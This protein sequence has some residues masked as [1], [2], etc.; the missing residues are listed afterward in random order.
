MIK[1]TVT[2][3]LMLDFVDD[4]FQIPV[5]INP[6]RV[7]KLNDK[8]IKDG[9]IV[10][11]MSREL[12]LEDN[13]GLLF[14]FN[15]AK[16]KHLPFKVVISLEKNFY[17]ERQLKFMK[18]GLDKLKKNL[19]ENNISYEFLED[20]FSFENIGGLVVDFN[21]INL[22]SEFAQNIDCAVFEVDSHNIIP[23]RYISYKQ[24]FSAATLRRKV[25]LNIGEF[26]TEYNQFFKIDR[27]EAGLNLANFIKN[28]LENYNLDKNDPN[29]DAVSNMSK[30]LH[31]GQISSQ[32][33]SIEVLKSNV[34]R[35]NK[36]AYLEELIVRKE[37]AD[38]FCLYSLS[39]KNFD[40]IL[41]WA[42]VS[43]N[44][45]RSD[46]KSYLYDLKEFEHAQTHDELW[47]ACQKKLLKEGKIH[48]YLRMYW[49]KK[50]LEW[51]K[52]P[53]EA[54]NIAIYLNDKYAL[55][56]NDSNGY[57]GIL[58]SIG[59]LHDRPFANR[60]VSGKIRYMSL[61]GCKNK[62]D[63]QKYIKEGE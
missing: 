30:Y 7:F 57:V 56:G 48:G 1:P 2:R 29:K 39:Y 6:N 28:K 22:K 19:A 34:S 35:A 45:H 17:S 8:E 4:K 26:L 43:L 25:Y 49:A 50:I 40:G 3:N 23:A 58:W 37:L 27:G 13:W 5:E 62:F 15:L 46:I 21:P 59:G 44:E 41:N 38:N 33:I 47:N 52:S 61:N 42:K 16:D 36:E 63:V 60:I 9:Q 51:S 12:R 24:E 20:G 31:C 32:R 10:Y 14:A 18:S 54:L 11:L 53:E 55:D